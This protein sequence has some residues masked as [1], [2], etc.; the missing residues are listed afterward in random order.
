MVVS[1][2]VPLIVFI[3]CSQKEFGEFRKYLKEMID[4]EEFRFSGSRMMKAELIEERRGDII[5]EDIKKGL[6]NCSI[7]VGIFGQVYSEWAIAEYFEARAN[8]LPLL[9]YYVKKKKKSRSPPQHGIRGR[10]SKV[11]QFLE[12][13]VKR[14]GI[15]IRGPY[16]NVES[17]Y[18]EILRDL[19]YEMSELAREA[20][21][22]RRIIHRRL[23]P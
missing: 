13:Q 12:A 3:S 2:P 6:E 14:F 20:V 17:L 21:S 7:Y 9:I 8:D 23:L 11:E 5:P 15:R 10:K 19:A 1:E 16:E 18:D 4:K 22:V